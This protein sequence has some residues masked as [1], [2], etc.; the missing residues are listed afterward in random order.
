[1]LEARMFL[2][3][4]NY[5]QPLEIIEKH[6]VAHRSF[7]E[8]GYKKDYFIVSGP[9]NPRTGGIILSQLKN[10]NQLMEI[11][12]QDPFYIHGIAEFEVIEF[13]PVK[14]HQNFAHFIEE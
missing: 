6:L 5:L 12:Q 1:M 14:Y 9:R 11:I 3:T 4:L 10:K 13:N 7:L 2:I 8:E